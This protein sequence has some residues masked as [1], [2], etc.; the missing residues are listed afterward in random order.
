MGDLKRSELREEVIAN[1][2]DRREFI[3]D[4]GTAR[5]KTLTRAFD[6]AQ[7]AIARAHPDSWR[8]LRRTDRVVTTILNT[9]FGTDYLHESIPTNFHKWLGLISQKT[10]VSESTTLDSSLGIGAVGAVVSDSTG[11]SEGKWITVIQ[12]DDT[13][14]VA[15]ITNVAVTIVL[16]T[17]GITVAAASGNVINVL[18]DE[19]P[20]YKLIQLPRDQWD[21]IIGESRSHETANSARFYTL[22]RNSSGTMQLLLF[23]VPDINHTLYR[24][25]TVWPTD[26]TNEDDTGAFERLDDIILAYAT[27]YC[28][29]SLQMFLEEQRWFQEYQSLLDQAIND[30]MTEPDVQYTHM[31]YG[32]QVMSNFNSI[33]PWQDPFQKRN[34]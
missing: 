1:L 29:R 19:E 15:Q 21:F 2:G 30:D 5:Y 34:L 7:M 27:A 25:Y 22:D 14:H 17:P 11:F 8:E 32:V 20:A 33:N 26:F 4:T 12:D 13:V 31:N 6:R 28:F 18:S 24:R 23:P 10:D 16:W 3:D 9:V